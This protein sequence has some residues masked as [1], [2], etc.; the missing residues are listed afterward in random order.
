M[1]IAVEKQWSQKHSGEMHKRML[2][3]ES[4]HHE[5]K[6]KPGTGRDVRDSSETML[7]IS[8]KNNYS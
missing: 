2:E 5:G 6:K 3:T 8:A 4:G 7:S 1:L